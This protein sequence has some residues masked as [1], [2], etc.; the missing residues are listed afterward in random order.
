MKHLIQSFSQKLLIGAAVGLIS[1]TTLNCQT[2][3]PAQEFSPGVIST[4]HEASI[5]FTPDGNELY[6]A[7]RTERNQPAHIY[8]SRR[9]NNIWQSPEKVIFGGEEW[10][11]FDP[12]VSPDGKTL[13]FVSNRPYNNEAPNLKSM[14]IWLST[15]T[16]EGW[17]SPRV[18][19]NVNSQSRDGTPT[20]DRRG[21]LYFFSDRKNGPN[22]DSIYKATLLKRKYASPVLLPIPIN[23]EASDTSPFISPNGKVLLFYSTRPGGL[24]GADIYVSTMKRGSWTEPV[25]L[26][27]LVNSKGEEDNPVMS[28]DG[29]QLFFGRNGKYYVIAVAG[30]PALKGLKLR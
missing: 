30:V 8:H 19:E 7:R 15:K 9:V 27:P 29:K 17:S 5:T 26:G 20:V 24:G 6:F 25:N 16:P 28:P 12:C 11:E 18:V 10:F 1:V 4:G 13:F 2:E 22:K 14:H 21:T 3:A 23:S